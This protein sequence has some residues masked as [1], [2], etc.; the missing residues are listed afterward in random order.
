MSQGSSQAGCRPLVF[1]D[2]PRAAWDRLVGRTARPTPFSRWTFHRAWWDAYGPTAHDQYMVCLDGSAAGSAGEALTAIVPLMHRHEHEPQD[3]RTATVLRHRTPAGTRVRPDAKAVF[4]GASYHADYA[5]LLCPPEDLATVTRAL[6]GALAG[7]PDTSHGS[8]PWDVV[9]LRRLR[10]DDPSLAALEEAFQATA[11]REQWTVHREREDV[12]PVVIVSTGSSFE[13][14]LAGLGKK[15]R[16]EIRRKLRRA[17]AAAPLSVEIAEPSQ[18]AIDG[19][20]AL[21]QKRFGSEG[22]F[23]ETEGGERSRHFVRRLAELELAEGAGRQLHVAR[24][25]SGER[26]IFA[27]LAFDDGQTCYLYNAGMDPDAAEL[28]PGISGTAE[29]LRDRIEAGRTRFD[30]MRGNEPY[31]YEW[32]AQD[33]PIE[34]LLVLREQAA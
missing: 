28:S 5:T 17:Q 26:L 1:E 2:I 25:R 19:F 33:E 15:S 30:F 12:C 4:F 10:T 6:V 29:Y 14:Y 13:D 16:H 18:E 32:G 31:K 20:V 21:H 24:V 22:L 23:P 11:E 3:E 34:R 7:P 9:D 8:Q 27:A